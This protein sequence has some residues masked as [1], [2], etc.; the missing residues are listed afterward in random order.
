[1]KDVIKIELTSFHL[2]GTDNLGRDLLNMLILATWNNLT[3]AMM[4]FQLEY[5]NQYQR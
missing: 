4:K 1:M 5:T 2:L 3:L